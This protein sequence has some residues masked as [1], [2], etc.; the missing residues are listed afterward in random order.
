[1]HTHTQREGPFY[2]ILQWQSSAR[3]KILPV[4]ENITRPKVAYFNF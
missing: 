4:D 1:M 3:V 2:V